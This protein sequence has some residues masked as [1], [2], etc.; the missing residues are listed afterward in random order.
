MRNVN[1]CTHTLRQARTVC[2]R[3]TETERERESESKKLA[4][5]KLANT[6]TGEFAVDHT[7]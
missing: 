4:F 6:K 2:V 5:N 7:R 3:S 1:I